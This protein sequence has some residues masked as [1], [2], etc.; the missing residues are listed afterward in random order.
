MTSLPI[1]HPSFLVISTLRLG[2]ALLTTPLIHSLRINYP[3]S[4]L[5]VLVLKGVKGIFEGNPDIDHIIEVPHRASMAQRWKEWKQLWHCYTYALSPVSSD[6]A[7]WYAF[8]AATIRIGFVNPHT[9]WLSRRLLSFAL[10][11]EDSD[12]HTI[13]HNLRLLEPLGAIKHVRVIPPTAKWILPETLQSNLIVIHPF[14]KFSYKS[15]PMNQWINLIHEIKRQH[16]CVI[17]LTGGNSPDELA[18]VTAV[19][20]QTHSINLSGQLSLAQ[21]T[22]LI[23]HAC[24][25][26]GPDTGVTHLA[27]ATGTPTIALFG[28]TNPVTWGPWPENHNQPTNPWIKSGTQHLGN[29]TLVQGPGPCVPCQ[30][31]GCAKNITSRSQCLD[32]ITVSTLLSLI[33]SPPCS[34]VHPNPPPLAVHQN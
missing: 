1:C 13:L 11:F 31:E 29:V 20:D 30:S 22:D 17:A 15:W 2:D 14:P 27:A 24:L 5:D 10:P 25:F 7:R 12:T 23:R 4:R 21:T 9:T 16:P 19:A 26:I 34:P 8:I 3:H 33:P 28:P 18:F 6:R 32:D